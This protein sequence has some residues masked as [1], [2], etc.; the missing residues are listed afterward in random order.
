MKGDIQNLEAVQRSFTARINVVKDLNYWE[1]LTELNMYSLER[2]RERYSIIYCW[3]IVNKL[4]PNIDN[5]LCIYTN[6]RRG[7][8]CRIPSIVS[9]A[10]TRV[11]NIRENS[12]LVRGPRLFNKLPVHLRSVSDVSVESFKAELDSFLLTVPDQPCFPGYPNGG[13][14]NSLLDILR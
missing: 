4:V 3:K 13:C 7:R 11:K 5:K 14:G 1:R 9:S 8:L 10:S 6:A 12:F 2:R